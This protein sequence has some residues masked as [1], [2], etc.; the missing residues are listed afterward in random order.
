[1]E[2]E[3]EL[4][5][6]EEVEKLEPVENLE[7]G[8]QVE[9]LVEEGPISTTKNDLVFLLYC[10]FIFD[11]R[12]RDGVPSVDKYL[13]ETSSWLRENNKLNLEVE[14]CAPSTLD[15]D[16]ADAPR[17]VDVLNAYSPE[18]P[19]NLEFSDNSSS[20]VAKRLQL[21]SPATYSYRIR[22][23]TL[24]LPFLHGGK[25]KVDGDI[26]FDAVVDLLSS[27]QRLA[28]TTEI[29]VSG[30]LVGC[31]PDSILV[32]IRHLRQWIYETPDDLLFGFSVCGKTKPIEVDSVMV[33]KWR[34]SFSRTDE[35]S[36]LSVGKVV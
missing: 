27:Q 14:P 28:F 34:I 25:I 16:D 1:M 35:R 36:C 23:G 8:E 21:E 32:A 31:D 10:A 9:N 7:P 30:S 13:E 22:S 12:T 5:S 26:S 2:E 20:Y 24:D 29:D 18:F 33:R 19:L 3:P 6:D 15:F 11:K 17:V 4:W